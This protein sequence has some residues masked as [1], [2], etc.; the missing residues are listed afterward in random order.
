MTSLVL[1]RGRINTKCESGAKESHTGSRVDFEAWAGL[2]AAGQ[3]MLSSTA[4]KTGT[5]LH[6]M[7]QVGDST[8]AGL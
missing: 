7:L 6:A 8:A 5:Y 1:S 2:H 3:M 4:A